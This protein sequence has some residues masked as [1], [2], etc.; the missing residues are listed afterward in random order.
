MYGI[1]LKFWPNGQFI[2]YG[3]CVV[4]KTLNG[5]MAN[6]EKRYSKSLMRY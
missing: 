1:N 3:P 2:A 4:Y 5:Y 6:F